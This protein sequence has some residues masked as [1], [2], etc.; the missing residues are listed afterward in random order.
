MTHT[1]AE[2]DVIYQK[3]HKQEAMYAMLCYLWHAQ[4]I[5]GEPRTLGMAQSQVSAYDNQRASIPR[6]KPR[7]VPADQFVACLY[8]SMVAGGNIPLNRG[9]VA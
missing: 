3:E 2:L 5:V 8:D 7:S 4:L 9:P 6:M 1:K